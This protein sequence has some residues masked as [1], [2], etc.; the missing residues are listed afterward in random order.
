MSRGAEKSVFVEQS[1]E[2]L[3][4]IK[5]NLKTTHL[6]E[7]ADVIRGDV[8]GTL[9]MLEGR[10]VFDIIFMDPPFNKG[11]DET[12]F[13]YLSKSSLINE[14]TIIVAELSNE[15]EYDYL[16]YLDFEVFKLKQYKNN[17]HI[18]CRRSV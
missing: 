15:T 10:Y 5:K 4:C 11:M 16:D 13:A 14:D 9:K 3:E 12:V 1:K 2:A 17:R 6:E 8:L 7:N 18:F